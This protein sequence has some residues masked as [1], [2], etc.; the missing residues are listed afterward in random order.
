MTV[1]FRPSHSFIL[2]ATV[3]I[4]CSLL[5]SCSDDSPEGE[6]LVE[7]TKIAQSQAQIEN[8][9][10]PAITIQEGHA[11]SIEA[12]LF[13]DD[14]QFFVSASS[15]L[16]KIHDASN[17]RIIR[18]FQTE[19]VGA[20]ALSTDNRYI[21]ATEGLYTANV[22]SLED[23]SIINQFKSRFMSAL[24][25]S[26]AEPNIIAFPDKNN[27]AFANVETKSIVQVVKAETE[28]SITAIDYS[29]N[30]DEIVAGYG[31]GTIRFWNVA[32]TKV[33]KTLAAQK[34]NSVGS[35]DFSPDGKWLLSSVDTTLHL[36]DVNG[37]KITRSYKGRTGYFFEPQFMPDSQTILSLYKNNTVVLWDKDS[38]K[39]STLTST[40]RDEP[41][42][43]SALSKDGK[44][45]SIVDY[46]R[47]VTHWNISNHQMTWSLKNQT[48]GLEF[49]LSPDAK[50]AVISTRKK[51]QLWDLQR[52]IPIKEKTVKGMVGN[53]YFGS[54]GQVLFHKNVN[55]KAH[56]YQWDS[57]SG[58][59]IS[60]DQK[61]SLNTI[62]GVSNN[63]HTFA[64]VS[65][66]EMAI[67]DTN[68]K[69]TI[70]KIS[71]DVEI[72][73]V[74]YS[75]DGLV[76]TKD[77]KDQQKYWDESTG[78]LVKERK[79]NF[80]SL[81]KTNESIKASVM[82]PDEKKIMVG[83]QGIFKPSRIMLIDIDSKQV[84]WSH[85]I[86]SNF[87]FS[88]TMTYSPD[89]LQVAYSISNKT[90][91]I[92]VS[93]GNISE[94]IKNG[95]ATWAPSVFYSK[96]NPVVFLTQSNV[97][98]YSS[99]TGKELYRII[100]F[101]E[102]EW[103]SITNQGF[104]N[105]S[106]NGAKRLNIRTAPLSVVPI[107]AFYEKFY[108]PDI[109]KFTIAGETID[110]DINMSD[111]ATPPKVEFIN[112]ASSTFNSNL[113][114]SLK[115][116]DMGGGIGEIRIYRNGTAIKIDGE[117]GLSRVKIAN[118]SEIKT[119]SISL[120]NGEN[121]L[122]AS[123]FDSNNIGRSEFAKL[124]VHAKLSK[125]KPK[126]HAVI[127]GIEDY[128]NSKLNLN[129]A[130]DDAQLFADSLRK[131][132][133]DLFDE[134]NIHLLTTKEQTTKVA[135]SQY[136]KKMQTL[137]PEDLFVFYVASHGTVDNGDYYLVTSNVGSTSTRM[138]KQ[139]ALT[140]DNLK[141]LL[142]NIPTSKKMIVLD[143]C[144]SQAMGDSLQVAL[145]TR[146]LSEDTA[147][148]VL[149]RAIGSTILTAST[150]T[151]EAL[152][153][154]KGHGLFTYVLSEGLRGKA[155]TN[156]DGFV[157]TSELAD[158]IEDEVP[159]LAEQVFG[160]EQFPSPARNGQSYPIT[161]VK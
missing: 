121:T 142:A 132:S 31:D 140:Q 40:K 122:T 10:K 28:E 108:R 112:T 69:S 47:G 7:P 134:I 117:R 131:Y 51:L 148:K 145:L 13:S 29:D 90:F 85:E 34:G 87:S 20:I 160:R 16:I 77:K 80:S 82:S 8:K 37:G 61:N 68:S 102:N 72:T 133:K 96:N 124:I 91:L 135:I 104:F 89:G 52:G 119:Y 3:I 93:D 123:A 57:K 43:Y 14:G 120:G 30:G 33:T 94:T 138:L 45:F 38:D 11:S 128:R 125:S 53:I 41:F 152:E 1:I 111:M 95:T 141:D 107:D 103:I 151:Q 143:T 92:D 23:G 24:E 64:I 25:F 86:E 81:L 146:G 76:V 36:W 130:V 75:R 150:S 98:A 84:I 50:R 147:M 74:R 126:L 44:Q 97:R 156:N 35:L 70:K 54:E 19:D 101:T 42:S 88:N 63:G 32:N 49:S 78:Q 149:S 155:D 17:G 83:T 139:D 118:N 79:L 55:H 137:A 116:T 153:G 12:L 48:I 59:I 105:A 99:E 2:L 27:I 9:P 71:N 106:E 26:P 113:E 158:Y 58:D 144:N 62:V 6:M 161:K 66:G 67:W 136:L 22:W 127:V 154:Y 5:I 56:V 110:T 114:L 129:F 157:K 60:T 109:V 115:V 73:S 65:G 39:R 46:H 21:A 15:N 100:P 4:L 18:E 159:A